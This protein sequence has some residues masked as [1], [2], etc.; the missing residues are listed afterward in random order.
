MD[1]GWIRSGVTRRTKRDE[2]LASF[3]AVRA[4]AMQ[5]S[6]EYAETGR[7]DALDRAV[8][9]W[10]RLLGHPLAG[11]VAPDSRTMMLEMAGLS[12]FTRFLQA[13]DAADLERAIKRYRDGAQAATSNPLARARLLS[14]F[15]DGLWARYERFGQA[16][17]MD[18]SID[19]A[20][21]SVSRVPRGT[22]GRADE[23]I[24][25]STRLR[26]RGQANRDQRDMAEADEIDRR[27]RDPE[28]SDLAL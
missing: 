6:E 20:R 17:D 4:Q 13:A 7:R 24:S 28:T 27:L 26:R 3:E 22:P 2:L 9:A 18:A 25:L 5:A 11:R 16:G 23:L 10:E 19:A 21:T 15:G 1:D 14:R 12:S 8:V